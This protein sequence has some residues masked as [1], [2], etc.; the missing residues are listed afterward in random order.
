MGKFGDS[1]KKQLGRDTG[2]FVSNLLFGDKHAAPVRVS[3]RETKKQIERERMEAEAQIERER[4]EAEARL[5]QQRLAAECE[6]EQQRRRD[7]YNLERQQLA[8]QAEAATQAKIEE[9]AAVDFPDD[10][11]GIIKLLDQWE[12]IL[13]STGAD[14]NNAL[15]KKYHKA[16]AH[17]Y[18][19]GIERLRWLGL[20][21]QDVARFR[22]IIDTYNRKSFWGR[23][24]PIVNT[25]TA[26][27]SQNTASRPLRRDEPRVPVLPE[28]EPPVEQ[29]RQDIPSPR[30]ETIETTNINQTPKNETTM[31]TTQLQALRALWRMYEGRLGDPALNDILG[32]GFC[33]S[34]VEDCHPVLV[35]G[36]NPSWREGDPSR[37][38]REL[39]FDYRAVVR[40]G[41]DS[42][43]T[44]VDA[45]FPDEWKSRVAYLDL[46][47]YRETD[48]K[49]VWKFCADPAGL[50]FV[51]DNL[52]ATQALVEETVRP[53]LIIVK[54][55]GSWCFWGKDAT[56]DANF[57]M[58]Y[59]LE[60][61]ET[62][63]C[64]D[65]CRIAG[66][67][68]HPDRVG[69][70]DIRDTNLRGALVLFTYDL[71]R[72]PKA[73]LPDAALV[74]RLCGMI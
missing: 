72:T 38:V 63:P 42:Y 22:Q 8:Q 66:L 74:A 14:A 37:A 30:I 65:L 44:R 73:K 1:F 50:R 4:M 57:W 6:L 60:P 9:I 18:Q 16:L 71:T 51:A 34:R 41:E 21:E 46:L 55:Q 52:A 12:V 35:T 33:Y 43:Y 5:N 31:N 10:S 40:G 47:N 2:R 62:L 53:R 54:N 32:R 11:A 49:T 36:I 61:V 27:T 28:T 26:G 69:Y 7:Q 64:G 39:V 70:R 67:I 20:D 68:D 23:L 59:R 15:S 13:L 45:L 25:F 48:Q 29:P 56:A 3:S 58:G 17:K 19:Q 24:Y